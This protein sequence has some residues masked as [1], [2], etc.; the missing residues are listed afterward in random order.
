MMKDRLKKYTIFALVCFLSFISFSLAEGNVSIAYKEK[1]TFVEFDSYEGLSCDLPSNPVFVFTRNSVGYAVEYKNFPDGEGSVEVKCQYVS[2]NEPAYL[3]FIFNYSSSN[4]DNTYV[5]SLDNYNPETSFDL[6]SKLGIARINSVNITDGNEYL[7]INCAVGG[8]TCTFKVSRNAPLQEDVTAHGEIK[9]TVAGHDTVITTKLTIKIFKSAS[10]RIAPGTYGTCNFGSQFEKKSTNLYTTVGLNDITLPTCT[11]NTEKYPLLEFVGWVESGKQGEISKQTLNS[12]ANYEIL[13]GTIDVQPTYYYFACYKASDGIAI[14]P[15]GAKVSV[16]DSWKKGVSGAYYKASTGSITLPEASFEGLYTSNKTFD[17]WRKAND[18]DKTIYPAGTSVPADGSTYVAAYTVTA[19]VREYGKT[20]YVNENNRLSPSGVTVLD[21]TSSDQSKVRVVSNTNSGECILQGVEAT[22]KN[23]PVAVVLR[24]ENDYEKTFYI[25]VVS[26]YGHTNSGDDPF[27]TDIIPNV[28]ATYNDYTSLNDYQTDSCNNFKYVGA[29]TGD[30]QYATTDHSSGV[31]AIYQLESQCIGGQEYYSLCL[32][33]GRLSPGAGTE[34]GRTEDI[35][36][37]SDFGLLLNYMASKGLFKRIKS[38]DATAVLSANVLIRIVSI[39]DSLSLSGSSNVNDEVYGA[40]YS[41]YEGLANIVR[42]HTDSDGK[43]KGDELRSAFTLENTKLKPEVY[44]IVID[45]LCEYQKEESTGSHGFERTIDDTKYDINGNDIKITYIGTMTIPGVGTNITASLEGFSVTGLKGVVEKWERNVELSDYTG[46]TVYNYQVRLDI[47]ATTL[48]VPSSSNQSSNQNAISAR[49]ES[50]NYSFKLTYES[51]DTAISDAFIAEPTGDAATG[52][53]Q[54]LLAFNPDDVTLYVYFSPAVQSSAC[55]LVPELNPDN[56]MSE[57]DHCTDVSANGAYTTTSTFN[58]SLFKAS[59]CCNLITD[60]NKYQYLVDNVCVSTCTSSTMPAV[61]DYRDTYTGSADFYNVIEGQDNTGAYKLGGNKSCIVYTDEFRGLIAEREEAGLVTRY[62]D[63]GNSLM[64]DAYKNNR[65]CRVSCSESWS[66]SMDS[67]GNYIGENAIAAGSY[68][69]VNKNDMFISGKRTCYTTFIDYGQKEVEGGLEGFTGFTRDIA[70]QSDILINAYNS[71]SNLSHTLS[72]IAGGSD[73]ADQTFEQENAVGT[74]LSHKYCTTSHVEYYCAITND[75]LN[76][77]TCKHTGS[78]DATPIPKTDPNDPDEEQQYSYSCDSWTDARGDSH[79]GELSGTTCTYEYNALKYNKCDSWGYC[80]LYSLGTSGGFND[81]DTCP[82]NGG[83]TSAGEYCRVTKDTSDGISNG[84][85]SVKSEPTG[86]TSVSPIKSGEFDEVGGSHEFGY[87]YKSEDE[88]RAAL[89]DDDGYNSQNYNGDRSGQ[90]D[91]RLGETGWCTDSDGGSVDLGEGA[92]CALSNMNVFVESTE[93]EP[94]NCNPNVH[95]ECKTNNQTDNP[96]FDSTAIISCDGQGGNHCDTSYG[97]R[98][99]EAV[100]SCSGAEDLVRSYGN[101]IQ[102]ANNTI[103]EYAEDMFAC[104]HF[105]LYNSADSVEAGM[106]NNQM[107]SAKFM[108]VTKQYVKLVTTFAPNISYA[109]DEVEYMTILG[110]DNIMERYKRLNSS[111]FGDQCSDPNRVT[112]GDENCY[113]NST[114]KR[115]PITI[116]SYMNGADNPVE[117]Q[118]YLSRNYLE[119]Y[120]YDE[121][122]KG[123]GPAQGWAPSSEAAISYGANLGISPLTCSGSDCNFGDFMTEDFGAVDKRTLMCVTGAPGETVTTAVDTVKGGGFKTSVIRNKSPY[124]TMGL[125]F[126]T[127]VEYVQANY[128]KSSIE[129][130]SFYKNKGYW[131]FNEEDVKEHGDTLT[132]ALENARNR[133]NGVTY[134]TSDEERYKW[135]IL[136][137]YNVFPIKMTTAR[138]IYQ[139]TYTF[140]DIGSYSTGKTGRIMGSDQSLIS[141]N[142]RTCF[143]EVFEEICLCCGNPITS[144]VGSTGIVD[145][146]EWVE[147]HTDYIPSSQ[148][149]NDSLSATLAFNTSTVS[150]SDMD[151]DSERELG[152]N[153]GSDSMFFYNGETFTTDKGAELL[154]EI[155]S[156]G[157]GDNIYSEVPEYSYTL[158]PSN[159]ASIREYN[160]TNGYEL[161]HDKLTSVARYSMVPYDPTDFSECDTLAGCRFDVPKTNDE[162]DLRENR[163]ISFQHYTSDF[164]NDYLVNVAGATV[165]YSIYAGVPVSMDENCYVTKG[166]T[167]QEM[168]DKQSSCRWVDYIQYDSDAKRYFRLSFK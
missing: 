146:D 129:N 95:E 141:T 59:G 62:D 15:N 90:E 78:A 167:P 76:G 144:H 121:S 130:S 132:Q 27:V 111:Y 68:F 165:N 30:D 24:G 21:C 70:E 6:A 100:V 104:Q 31:L 7:D 81:D 10:A 88:A 9:Y 67:Y 42:A 99:R 142:N 66:L 54:R 158:T 168:D 126:V 39:L 94:E 89:A 112:G 71:M 106:K 164:L 119:T 131:Y 93:D 74:D 14:F 118:A 82:T 120:Y 40:A 145:S 151:S 84:S 101:T 110:D 72:D 133:I 159:L 91:L 77:T 163:L 29:L 138:D 83:E 43:I 53:A 36:S 117:Q 58:A 153:W 37:N 96:S 102:G 28:V 2:N 127:R 80:V 124:W 25:T 166:F 33:A 157:Q 44:N 73:E 22:E 19:T 12:C 108:G 109:Y 69:Q 57:A 98:F 4:L 20:I 103:V 50:K 150:L 161:N 156:D 63:A 149:P 105:E 5:F 38:R 34:Y 123:V 45:V 139:Y 143:Y 140:A 52:S 49:E 61:C 64:V 154:K 134:S 152:N 35:A 18:S 136:G 55:N 23:S 122:N 47:D 128:I 65:Y 155:D 51:N 115:V 116:K 125:C 26:R 17:G 46:R 87:V 148:D 162:N 13:N 11:P 160:D 135:S 85:D 8:N 75:S 86:Y 32:D 16:D 48:E 3:S 114:N 60:E 79:S 107:S 1:K 113:N 137:D 56:C 97:T 41:Y 147:E 92:S